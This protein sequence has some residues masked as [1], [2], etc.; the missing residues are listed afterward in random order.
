M[1]ISD[2]LSKLNE[3]REQGT[4]SEQ[5]FEA[6][7]AKVLSG[8]LSSMPDALE[9]RKLWPM[10]IHLT[11]LCGCLVPL[12]GWIVP[13]VIWQMQKDKIPECDAHGRA[14]ANWLISFL[15]YSVV[16]FLLAFVIIGIP[17]LFVL[18]ILAVVFPVI[19]AIKANNG[20]LWEYPMAIRFV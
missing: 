6:A 20:E 11:Q 15:I 17:I 19:G 18:G 2:E 3:L 1:S 4:L 9:A 5:E 10:L 16:A 13:I 12:V 8:N 7:K 14:V